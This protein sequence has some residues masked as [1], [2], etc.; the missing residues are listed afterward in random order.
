MSGQHLRTEPLTLGQ[1]AALAVL[2]G[3][4]LAFLTAIVWAAVVARPHTEP[5]PPL[6][7]PVVRVIDA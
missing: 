2:I 1:R 7:S 4:F 3:V 5:A 6:P